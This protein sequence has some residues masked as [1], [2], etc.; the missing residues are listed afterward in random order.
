MYTD[1][2]LYIDGQWLNG[3]NRKTE[4]V[5]NPATGKVLGKLPHASKADLA[6]GRK[7][8]KEDGDVLAGQG[9]GL[10]RMMTVRPSRRPF[11][12][13]RTSSG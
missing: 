8:A 12:K 7:A 2:Q 10:A 13:L 9:H 11:D 3:A 6:L 5:V 1:L 4:D